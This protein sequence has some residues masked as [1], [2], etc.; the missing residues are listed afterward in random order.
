MIRLATLLLVL[1]GLFLFNMAPSQGR[2]MLGL[3]ALKFHR[4]RCDR[5]LSDLIVS[6]RYVLVRPKWNL[7]MFSFLQPVLLAGGAE[8]Y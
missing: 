3:S 5:F 7:L 1:E 4:L 8:G 6:D 2:L